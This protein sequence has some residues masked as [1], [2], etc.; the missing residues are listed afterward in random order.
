[1]LAI[2]AEDEANYTA[3]V[4]APIISQGDAIGA[5]V[6]LSTKEGAALDLSLI[7]IFVGTHRLLGKDVRFKDL[8]LLIVDEEQ[9]FGVA[10]KEKI[11]KLKKNIDVLTLSATPIPRTL[12][13]SM[14]GIRDLSVLEN[15]PEERYPVQ[16]YVIEY[17]EALVREAVNR[18]LSRGGQVYMVYNR[19]AGIDR[20]AARLRLMMPGVRV[21]VAHGQMPEGA[22]EDVMMSFM[23][24]EID[25]LLCT[26]I[27]ENGLDIPT[28]N[29]I[30]VCDSERLGLSQLYQLR[31]RVGRS[32]RL[33]YAYFT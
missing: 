17:N 26:T 11:K 32:N 16:T 25:L 14:I 33:A 28:T 30:I 8:G 21:G 9:R 5:V 2:T 20:F 6:L 13:M 10:H 12:H 27:I 7:H 22:L 31:G 19:V 1:M 15:P 29:T 24:H 4:V 23:N 18:E 3:Q